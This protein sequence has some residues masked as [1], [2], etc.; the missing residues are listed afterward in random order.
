M[1]KYITH[2]RVCN[3]CSH[4]DTVL[5][6]ERPCFLAKKNGVFGSCDAGIGSDRSCTRYHCWKCK[7]KVLLIPQPSP[8]SLHLSL[9]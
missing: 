5:I 9:H 3:V 2:L 8:V 7:E 4:Q 6:S 1:C